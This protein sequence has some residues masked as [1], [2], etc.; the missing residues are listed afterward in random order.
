MGGM[1]GESEVVCEVQKL[2][3]PIK[4]L[5]PAFALKRGACSLGMFLLKFNYHIL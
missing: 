3:L 5:K 2:N 4:F 1:S